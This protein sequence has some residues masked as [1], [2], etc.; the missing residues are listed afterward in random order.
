MAPAQK[1]PRHDL[2]IPDAVSV[3]LNAKDLPARMGWGALCFKTEK[4][5]FTQVSGP[6]TQFCFPS[7]RFCGMLDPE[8]NDRAAFG[9]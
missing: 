5:S 9:R 4:S 8:M 7:G 2:N 3:P 6:F 1:A